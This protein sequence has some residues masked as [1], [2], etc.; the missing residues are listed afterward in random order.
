[1]RLFGNL[2]KHFSDNGGGWGVYLTDSKDFYEN[3]NTEIPITPEEL[4]WSNGIC[5]NSITLF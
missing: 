3:F 4:P 5:K 2:S 1:M